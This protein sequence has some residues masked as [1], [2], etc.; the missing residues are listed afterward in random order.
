MNNVLI[1]ICHVNIMLVMIFW[2]F[3]VFQYRLNP[4]QVKVLSDNA[5]HNNFTI[6]CVSLQVWFVTSRALFL[7]W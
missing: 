4:P 3:N 5:G 2:S 7:E 1:I 6:Y